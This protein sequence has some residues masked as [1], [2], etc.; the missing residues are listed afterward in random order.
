MC[1]MIIVLLAAC[2]SLAMAA[3]LPK[4]TLE[5]A[6]TAVEH[7]ALLRD[8]ITAHDER[9]YED[10]I[11]LYR[12]ILAENADDL[13]TIYELAFSQFAAGD[14]SGCAEAARLGARYDSRLLIRLRMSLANCLDNDGNTNEAIDIYKKSIRKDSEDHLLR[15]NY[16]VTLERLGDRAEAMRQVKVAATLT[17]GH[18]S[19]HA[20]LLRLYRADGERIPALLAG[21]RFLVLEP[22]S[23]R[24]LAVMEEFHDLIYG[25]VSEKE[26]GN[27]LIT[28]SPGGDSDEGEFGG[29]ELSLAIMNAAASIVEED[30]PRPK[31]S[32]VAQSASLVRQVVESA[33]G[34]NEKP[35]KR[36]FA[37]R[38]YLPYFSGLL[39][40]GNLETA[41]FMAYSS[42]AAEEV[43][44]WLDSHPEQ[45]SA[46]A[47]WNERYRGWQG[48]VITND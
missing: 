2:F 3:D 16:A 17:P 34:Q 19:S 39:E 13:S 48:A 24:S 46:L 18:A 42:S 1:K 45:V 29:A 31:L 37:A 35:N 26:N 41:V 32:P 33:I 6:E 15:F 14:F 40:S 30:D 22:R 5:A 44:E 20:M 25:S 27:L 28:V 38:Y 21:L 7:K 4:V 47:E 8:G 36:E 10:A 11:K 23:N 12:Q 9:R 43:V